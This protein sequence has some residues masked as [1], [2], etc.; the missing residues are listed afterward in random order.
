[1]IETEV[2]VYDRTARIKYDL[3]RENEIK[4]SSNNEIRKC[5]YYGLQRSNHEV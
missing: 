4:T 1:M 2:Y 3:Y 5:G